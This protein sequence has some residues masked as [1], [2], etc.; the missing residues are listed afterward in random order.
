MNKKEP[1]LSPFLICKKAVFDFSKKSCLMGVLNTTPDSFSDG[2]NYPDIISAVEQG[3]RMVREG[4]DIIDVG[5][6][7][8]RPGSCP[9]SEKE[10]LDRVIPVITELASRISIPISI[11]TTKA[12]VAKKAVAAGAEIINDISAMRFDP[13]M[14][15]VVAE[16][17]VPVII[18]HM[19]ENPRT[20]QKNIRYDSLIDDILG[21]LS[22]IIDN[23]VKNGVQEDKIVVDPGIGFG[24]S[25]KAGDNFK[26]IKSLHKFKTL[27][28]PLLV[29]LSRKAFVTGLTGPALQC[30]DGGSAAAAAIAVCNGADIIRTHNIEAAKTAVIIADAIKR[31]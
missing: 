9:V 16:T 7:S 6:E 18:M 13:E 31:A 8:T 3:I 12:A 11:D 5:G 27:G 17:G 28:M 29:G 20:M 30:R 22:S 23:A 14:L 25:L 21:F 24:K 26:I 1:F 19:L 2:G 4:V 10:E 15:Y